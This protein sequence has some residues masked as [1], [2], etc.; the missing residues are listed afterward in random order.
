MASY[1]KKENIDSEDS[2]L[3]RHA[4]NHYEYVSVGMHQDIFDE[5]IY[6]YSLFTTVV[7]LY[8]RTRPYIY[9]ARKEQISQGAKVA[10]AF[11]DFERLACRWLDD[12]LPQKP[13]KSVPA[14]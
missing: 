9:Q 3:I 13:V 2:K 10:T 4:L 7:R 8:E 11:Q 5:N 14:N 12:P 6:K 1:A